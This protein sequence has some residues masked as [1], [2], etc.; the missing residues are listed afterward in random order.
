MEPA[1]LYSLVSVLIVSS[2][3]LIG[4]FFLALNERRLQELMHLFVGLAAGAL[5]GD[6]FIHLVPEA[7]EEGLKGTAFSLAILGG[8]LVFFI[9]EK[10]LRWHHHEQSASHTHLP[11][12]ETPA[13]VP[14]KPLGKLVLVG[15][16]VHNFVDGAVIA[17]SFLISPALGVAT[18]A[19]VFLHEIPQEIAD[20]ALL[21]HAGFSRARALMWNFVSALIAILGALAF[22]AIGELF[23]HIEPLAAAFT[24]GAF[25]YIAAADLIPELH[26]TKHPGKSALQFI[27]VIVGIALMFLLL[28][29]E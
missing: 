2:V 4:V 3:S 14:I 25:I 28:V 12:P 20:F 6:A 1:I 8:M 26:E 15:D 29:L 10:Y 22:F 27:A 7:F 17:A 19:A 21:L 23:E 18:T 16:G 11:L 5:L 24:A 13:A 9:L